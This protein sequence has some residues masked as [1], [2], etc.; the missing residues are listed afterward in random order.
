MKQLIIITILLVPLYGQLTND[1]LF[2][3]SVS[4]S[5]GEQVV[6]PIYIKNTVAYQGWQIPI[7][8]GD[9]NSPVYCDSISEVGS[10][11]ENW[12]WK[13]YFVNNC[14]WDNVQTCGAAGIV[15]MMLQDSLEPGYWLVTTLYITIDS[16]ASP[17]T[18][19]VDTTTASWYQGGPQLDYVVSVHGQS[20]HTEVVAGSITI[21][22]IGVAE[23]KRNSLPFTITPTIIHAGEPIKIRFTG[24]RNSRVVL[25]LIDISGR[26]LTTLYDGLLSRG[27]LEL[28]CP[29][30]NLSPGIYFL[31]LTGADETYTTKILIY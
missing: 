6:L 27:N 24:A 31:T 1:T 21:E 8:F 15:D 9:G 16:N 29:S 5:P 4:G 17:Q 30:S 10:C 23:S 2:I 7:R 11:M 22:G 12:D 28:S 20:Y 25:R 19:P 3:P 18:I 14:E 13:S 26:I